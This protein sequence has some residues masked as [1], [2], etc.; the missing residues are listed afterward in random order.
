MELSMIAACLLIAACSHPPVAP[1][2][3]LARPEPRLHGGMYRPW[4]PPPP[5]PNRGPS[6]GGTYGGPGDTAP[7]GGPTLPGRGP[8]APSPG[9]AA[10][11]YPGATP[12]PR[13]PGA[14]AGAP[15]GAPTGPDASGP[16]T[17]GIEAS[18]DPTTWRHWWHF[19]RAPYLDLRRHL[20]A[21]DAWTGS[22]DFF[23]GHG[24]RNAAPPTLRPS[25]ELVETRVVPALLRVLAEGGSPDVLTGTL[26]ALA[27][28]RQPDD[29]QLR[30]FRRAG[31][32]RIAGQ[33]LL[34]S[35]TTAARLGRRNPHRHQLP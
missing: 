20:H 28:I 21:I 3:L 1:P 35:R 33:R 14:P 22:D 12:F 27:K 13:S 6:P 29:L 31:R 18:A 19:N 15:A 23:L 17:G 25:R 34:P 30:L 9:A 10:R 4:P 32:N 7:G 16:T 8:A 26:I 11:G 5:P 2:A 24:G